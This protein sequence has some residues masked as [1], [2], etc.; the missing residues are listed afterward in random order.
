[1]RVRES[2]IR[3][4]RQIAKSAIEQGILVQTEENARKILVPLLSK[5]ADGRAVTV[6]FAMKA[7]LPQLR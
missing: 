3:T 4:E 2:M 1:M 5:V 6:K 7:T